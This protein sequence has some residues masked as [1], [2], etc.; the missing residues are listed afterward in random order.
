MAQAVHSRYTRII[1]LGEIL[2]ILNFMFFH[3]KLFIFKITKELMFP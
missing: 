3:S 1:P 2:I